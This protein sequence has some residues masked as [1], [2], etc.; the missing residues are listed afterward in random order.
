MASFNR[1]NKIVSRLFSTSVLKN[2]EYVNK[3]RLR[4]FCIDDTI[5]ITTKIPIDSYDVK[6]LV[7]PEDKSEFYQLD[8]IQENNKYVIYIKLKEIFREKL[9]LYHFKFVFSNSNGDF[10][11][12]E[13]DNGIGDVIR[14]RQKTENYLYNMFLYAEREEYPT[15]LENGIIY[16]IFTDRFFKGEKEPVR[17][18]AVINSDWYNGIPAYKAEPGKR[19]K[20]N[21]FFGGDLYGI[22]YKMDY[23]ASLGVSCIYLNPIFESF[24]NHKY[25]TGDYNKIDDMFGGEK[26]FELLIKE[27]DKR[28]IKVIL[29]GVFNHT[30]DDSIYF[31][32][33]NRYNSVGA[34]NSKDS[35]YYDWYNFYDYPEQYEGWWGFKTL[36]RVNCDNESYQEFL[37]GENG[38]I[39][40]YLRMG[41]SGYRLDVVDELSDEFLV[42]LKKTVL[43]EKKDA[44]VVGEVWE[45]AITK[46]SYGYRRKYLCGNEVDSVMNYPLR[47]AIIQYLKYKDVNQLQYVCEHIYNEYPEFAQKYA[48]NTLGT[49]DTE[50]IITSLAGEDYRNLSKDEQS[51][52][53]LTDEEYKKGESLVKFAYIISNFF[54]GIPS[55]YYGDEIGMQGYTD[56]FNRRPYPWGKENEELLKFYRFLGQARRNYFQFK[57]PETRIIFIDSEILCLEKGN[58][59]NP[60]ITVINTSDSEYIIKTNSVVQNIYTNERSNKH[61]VHANDFIILNTFDNPGDYSVYKNKPVEDK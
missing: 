36:P 43:E 45:N 37:F 27:A 47:N 32:R 13:S 23:I 28:N 10:E 44:Y 40:K 42:K 50:R 29:D 57:S 14:F 31:N 41:I 48:F 35:K 19:F 1:K 55:V 33:E 5:K 49:H 4:A 39:R 18:D 22:A 38:I 12:S 34:Y 60:L 52:R 51:V 54:P 53:M 16:Q 9:G 6:I 21:M 7:R 58:E 30:G 59:N 46:V 17:E 25:D 26:A 20:N 61:I 24:S 8:M 56:P 2:G 11:L 15:W 3:G